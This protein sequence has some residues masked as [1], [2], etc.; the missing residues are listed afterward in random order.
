MKFT[1]AGMLAIV[2]FVAIPVYAAK[3][4]DCPPG[5]EVQAQRNETVMSEDLLQKRKQARDA[6]IARLR[7]RFMRATAQAQRAGAPEQQAAR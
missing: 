1:Q 7:E 6:D 5:Q 3:E 2:I 4:F